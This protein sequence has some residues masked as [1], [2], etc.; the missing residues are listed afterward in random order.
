VLLYGSQ[1]IGGAVNV[2]DK[3]IPRRVPDEPIHVDALAAYDSVNDEYQLGGS[4]DAPL[5]GGFVA[6]VS[7]SYRNADDLEVPGFVLSDSLRAD[8]LADAAEEEAEGELEKRRVA[9]T[10]GSARHPAQQLCQ[11][12]ERQCRRQLLR[13]GEHAGCVG[14]VV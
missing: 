2:I 1:A 7:G 12:V 6:H 8:L 4:L 3:R 5:G 14:R 11:G 9:R 10:R 13:R